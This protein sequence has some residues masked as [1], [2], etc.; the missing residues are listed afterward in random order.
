MTKASRAGDPLHSMLFSSFTVTKCSIRNFKVKSYLFL[1]TH[2]KDWFMAA[3]LH[4]LGQMIM[5]AG[6]CDMR[7]SSWYRSSGKNSGTQRARVITSSI[8]SP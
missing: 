6:T 4:T 5:A 3:W 2:Q 8:P 1:L 7:G